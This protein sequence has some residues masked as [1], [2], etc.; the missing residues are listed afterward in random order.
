MDELQ[1]LLD[2]YAQSVYRKDLESLLSIYDDDI[3]AYD[4]WQIWTYDGIKSWREMNTHWFEMVGQDRDVITFE[5]VRTEKN[6]EL[7]SVSAIVRYAA[8]NEKGEE[9]RHM[10]NRLTWVLRKKGKEW[11][12]FHQHT[13]SPIDFKSMKVMIEK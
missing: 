4:M 2:K 13:S 9:L 6:N 3:I 11:K 7:G 8:V 12:V 5:E 10:F 1:L